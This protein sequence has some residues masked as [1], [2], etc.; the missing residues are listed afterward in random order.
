MTEKVSWE[1]DSDAEAMYPKAYPATLIAE[2]KDGQILSAHVDYPK[3]DPENPATET[4]II[5]KFH[6]LS[7]RHLDKN[8]REKIINT[9]NNLDQLGN[10]AELADLIR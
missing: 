7:E 2:L 1:F 5:S 9:V 6:S 8:K 10:V 3:G 4:E